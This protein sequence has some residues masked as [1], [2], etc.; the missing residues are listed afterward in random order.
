[1]RHGDKVIEK[2]KTFEA[3]AFLGDVDRLASNLSDVTQLF[4]AS[5]DPTVIAEIPGLLAA[6]PAAARLE[7][8][9]LTDSMRLGD[10]CVCGGVR[11]SAKWPH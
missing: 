8:F 11:A 2:H 1:M 3:S 9:S 6:A 7:I 5:D 10:T 4:V